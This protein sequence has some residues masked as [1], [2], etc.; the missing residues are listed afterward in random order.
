MAFGNS[1]GRLCLVSF[2]QFYDVKSPALLKNP[3]VTT[4]VFNYRCVDIA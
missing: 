4:I 1:C 3:N 2:F